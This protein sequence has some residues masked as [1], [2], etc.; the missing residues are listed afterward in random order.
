M[1]PK[2]QK[3]LTQEIWQGMYGVDGTEDK[4]L[5]GDF[6]E[7]RVDYGEFKKFTNG[8]LNKMSTRFK[9]LVSFL[10]G[11]G[12]LGGSLWGIFG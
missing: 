11:S 1:T 10:I 3:Q 12:V 9:I 8:R 6:K 2:T 7:L 4:G 5:I